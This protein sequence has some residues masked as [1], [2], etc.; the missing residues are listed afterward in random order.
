MITHTHHDREKFSYIFF[1]NVAVV[2]VYL[3]GDH[4]NDKNTL[5][6]LIQ[7]QQIETSRDIYV[8]QLTPH[9]IDLGH[10]SESPSGWEER[11]ER[12][13]MKSQRYLGKVSCHAFEFLSLLPH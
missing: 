13:N 3:F 1:S 12:K 11:Y 10:L 7:Y 8:E 6:F 4:E 9:Q 2:I 5:Y